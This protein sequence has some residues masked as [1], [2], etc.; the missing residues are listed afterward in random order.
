MHHQHKQMFSELVLTM[1]FMY[2]KVDGPN[3]EP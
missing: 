2:T 1:T 3:I